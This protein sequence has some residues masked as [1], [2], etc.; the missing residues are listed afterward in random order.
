MGKIVK[1]K[2]RIPGKT[3]NGVFARRGIKLPEE[4]RWG[5]YIVTSAEGANLTSTAIQYFP[6]GFEM[7]G[8]ML[9][10]TEIIAKNGPRGML[11]QNAQTHKPYVNGLTVLN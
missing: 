9:P 4:L 6:E 1:H 10:H 5:H 3:V 7:K 2:Y 8:T 11:I